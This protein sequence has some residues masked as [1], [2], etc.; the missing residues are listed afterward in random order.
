MQLDAKW[1]KKNLVCR[2]FLPQH[3]MEFFAGEARFV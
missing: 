2:V 3:G 1:L